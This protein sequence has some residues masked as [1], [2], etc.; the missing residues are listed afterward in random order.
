[1]PSTGKR[2]AF[3]GGVGYACAFADAGRFYAR[4]D[5]DAYLGGEHCHAAPDRYASGGHAQAGKERD[6]DK[7]YGTGRY[8]THAHA[9]LA[10][11]GD[12]RE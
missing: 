5:G 10:N 11:P 12:T 1:L 8:A 2:D 6:A 7:G 3:I 4:A 9:S